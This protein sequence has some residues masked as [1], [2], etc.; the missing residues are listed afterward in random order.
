MKQH[1][2]A[3]FRRN[4]ARLLIEVDQTSEPLLVTTNKGEDQYQ[5]TV[6]ISEEQYIMMINQ[7]N[8]GK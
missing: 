6:V 2:S 1:N 3:Y 8:G 7:I 5:R 4:M